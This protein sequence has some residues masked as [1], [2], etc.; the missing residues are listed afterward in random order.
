MLFCSKRYVSQL[1]FNSNKGDIK[2]HCDFRTVDYYFTKATGLATSGK[3][4]K[5]FSD[6][7]IIPSEKIRLL[8]C[9]GQGQ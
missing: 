1:P 4:M 5:D 2:F 6:N 3:M 9:V 7:F 8:D